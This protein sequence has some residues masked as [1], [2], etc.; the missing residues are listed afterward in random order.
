MRQVFAVDQGQGSFRTGATLAPWALPMLKVP[1]GHRHRCQVQ[2][3]QQESVLRILSSSVKSPSSSV[4]EVADLRLP[5]P[6][7]P[8]TTTHH[9]WIKM[10]CDRLNPTKSDW[11]Q[12]SHRSPIHHHSRHTSVDD[13]RIACSCCSGPKHPADWKNMKFVRLLFVC[14]SSFSFI[15]L[16]L[17]F[18]DC[19]VLMFRWFFLSRVS[20][21]KREW[22][23]P[24]CCVCPS[25]ISVPKMRCVTVVID[26]KCVLKSRRN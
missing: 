25:I 3:V 8:S 4:K 13:G 14:Y 2:I 12:R 7:N 19:S 23:G 5:Q 15:Y 1:E 22:R 16:L 10:L 17:L 6:T 9:Q 18:C 20:C 24:C 26:V 21:H 11:D